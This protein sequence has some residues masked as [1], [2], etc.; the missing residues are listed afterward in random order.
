LAFEWI[1]T[2]DIPAE[3]AA[4]LAR[5]PGLL[6]APGSP[7]R[8]MAGALA[9][10]RHGR[11]AGVPSLGT[12]GGFQHMV[13][14]FA[15][16]VLGL[17]DADHAETSPEAPRL[18]VTPLTCSLAGQSHPVRILPGTLAAAIYGCDRSVEPFFCN[19]GLNPEFRPLLEARGLK[20]SG[21]GEDGQVRVLELEGHPFF[22]GNLYVPQARTGDGPH[23]VIAAFAAAARKR[24]AATRSAASAQ[25][26]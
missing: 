9:A 18:A 8:S 24:F 20:V 16:N 19:F 5:Y 13:V 7:Y 14:E 2:G 23:P 26:D 3:P 4:R 17:P 25:N 10:I 11:T 6:I 22:L 21:L 1:A 12:C 15:R